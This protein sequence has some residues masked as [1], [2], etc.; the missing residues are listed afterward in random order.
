MANERF[1]NVAL[2]LLA[3]DNWDSFA[4]NFEQVELTVRERLDSPGEQSPFVYFPTSA[5]VSLVMELKSAET[6]ECGLVGVEGYV[7]FGNTLTSGIAGCQAV[8]Q[9]PGTALRIQ[10]RALEELSHR[11]AQLRAYQL[12]YGEYLI[13]C[14]AQSVACNAFHPLE[15]RLARRLLAMTDAVHSDQFQLTHELLGQMLG[16]HRPTVTA[17]ARSLQ[18][19][20]GIRYRYGRIGILDREVLA[21]SACECYQANRGRLEAL[22]LPMVTS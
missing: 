3:G 9:L 11:Y 20:G 2:S 15:P 14:V 7:P 12:R 6:I 18:E 21:A 13:A 16:A 5:V 1:A 17:A 8:V 4:G 22:L 19:K 10:W